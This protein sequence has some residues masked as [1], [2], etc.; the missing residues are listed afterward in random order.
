MVRSKRDNRMVSF[1]PGNEFRGSD[2]MPIRYSRRALRFL[3][4]RNIPPQ[5]STTLAAI[6]LAQ[7]LPYSAQDGLIICFGYCICLT[8]SLQGVFCVHPARSCCVDEASLVVTII[9]PSGQVSQR[10][11]HCCKCLCIILLRGWIGANSS[12]DQVFVGI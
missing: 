10:V 8:N 4:N 9:A 12:C 3:G 1:Y 11:F 5:M 6:P 7:Q 2:N